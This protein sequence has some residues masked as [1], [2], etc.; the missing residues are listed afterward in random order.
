MWDLLKEIEWDDSGWKIGFFI[1]SSIFLYGFYSLAKFL[2][3]KFI[4]VIE[5][6]S[7]LTQKMD[8]RIKLME[9]RVEKHDEHIDILMRHVLLATDNPK[10]TTRK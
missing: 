3:Q 10:K 6:L 4:K 8:V 1:V 7:E 5:E 2:G 9:D